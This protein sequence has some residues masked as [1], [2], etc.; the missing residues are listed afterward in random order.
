M[1]TNANI[2]HE[3]CWPTKLQNTAKPS[4]LEETSG[5]ELTSFCTILS[6]PMNVINTKEP[7]RLGNQFHRNTVSV[8][9]PGNRSSITRFWCQNY[10]AAIGFLAGNWNLRTYHNVWRLECDLPTTCPITSLLSDSR[11]MSP[12]HQLPS[13]SQA[14]HFVHT[15]WEEPM[16]LRVPSAFLP[17]LKQGNLK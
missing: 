6:W 17:R 4:E 12:S 8:K 10:V 3:L 14:V 11:L 9:K 5:I 1:H 7:R 13:L 2:T 15:Q 16:R